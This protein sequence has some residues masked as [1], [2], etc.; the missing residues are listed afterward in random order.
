MRRIRRRIENLLD[1]I[2]RQIAFANK[3]SGTAFKWDLWKVFTEK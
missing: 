1:F 2:Q 3:R